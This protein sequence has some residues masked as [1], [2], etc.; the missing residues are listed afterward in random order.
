VAHVG[1]SRAYLWRRGELSRLT[2]DHSALEQ[3]SRDHPELDR[4]TF[5]KSPL[6]RILTRCLGGERDAAPEIRPLSLQSGDRLLLCCDG[7]SD[8]VP[9]SSIAETLAAVSAPEERCARLI[10]AANEA[11]GKDNVTAV[12]VNVTIDSTRQP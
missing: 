3:F 9:D 11:G 1:D 7:L 10:S 8:M 5:E 4:V 6:A 2:R 12:V